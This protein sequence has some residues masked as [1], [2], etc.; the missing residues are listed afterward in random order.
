LA[1][2]LN[3]LGASAIDC[4]RAYTHKA[5][6]TAPLP[7]AA[8]GLSRRTLDEAILQRARSC[9]AQVQ[10]GRAVHSL[11]QRR[12]QWVAVLEDKTTVAARTAFLATG[13]HD[14]RGFRRPPGR[15]NDMIGFKLHW[16]LVTAQRQALGPAVELF[17]FP[18]GYAGLEIVE[19]GIANLCLV[20]RRQHFKRLDNQWACLLSALRGELLPLHARLGGGEPC[21]ERPLAISRI[22]YGYLRRFADRHSQ[23]AFW[24]D[25]SLQNC[26]WHLGDQAAVIPSFAGEGIAIALHSARLAAQC[27]LE[28]RSQ[29]E[30]QSRLA[31]AIDRPLRSA[32]LLSRI[33]VHAPAQAI[34]M[35]V[36]RRAPS[37]IGNI[38]RRTRIAR[39]DDMNGQI[40]PSAAPP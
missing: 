16:R 8:F 26:P 23:N 36:L 1:I 40:S 12:A 27:Y 39:G 30:F 10:R 3:A 15:Q 29:A 5:A 28:G 21:C 7:F 35:A 24:Q 19:N 32:T 4:V 6:V 37:L 13:K 25:G 17:L 38:A 2:D 20:I 33:L 9:G 11:Q 14:L 31:D 34:A 22:P 18:G